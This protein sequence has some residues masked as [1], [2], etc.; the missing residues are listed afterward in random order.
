MTDDGAIEYVLRQCTYPGFTFNVTRRDVMTIYLQIICLDGVCNV[1]GRRVPWR[2]RKW[3]LSPHM[4]KD[5]IVQTALMA[6]LAAVEHEAREKFKYKGA[7]IFGPH[8]NV[9]RLATLA[10]DPTSISERT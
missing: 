8:F 10:E 4:T 3:L 9:D 6:T 1:S 5:E 7:A 2:G